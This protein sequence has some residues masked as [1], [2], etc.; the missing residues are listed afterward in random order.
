MKNVGVANGQISVVDDKIYIT[1][2]ISNVL[3]PVH[4]ANFAGGMGLSPLVITFNV[5]AFRAEVQACRF[6]P[7]PLKSNRKALLLRQER[8]VL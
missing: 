3:T 5:N 4:I 2:K 8:R 6:G 7:S 1:K